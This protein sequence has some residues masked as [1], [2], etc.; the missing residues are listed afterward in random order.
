MKDFNKF[1]QGQQ[2]QPTAD[3]MQEAIRQQKIIREAPYYTCEHCG[4]LN[5]I[6]I[7]RYKKISGLLDGSG[8]DKR[9]AVPV[10]ACA[11]CGEVPS[12]YLKQIEADYDEKHKNKE[13]KE[14]PKSNIITGN[15][16]TE[17]KPESTS[18][19]KK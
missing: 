16:N 3:E 5:F 7:L 1:Q 8:E 14:E 9:I 2:R 11:D 6:Q 15:F 12:E 17:S 4:G 18:D 19:T 13:K 10:V